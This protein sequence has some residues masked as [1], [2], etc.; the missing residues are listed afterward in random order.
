MTNVAGMDHKEWGIWQG[1]DL[2]DCLLQ[3]G[4]YIFVRFFVEAHVAV[5]N[6]DKA[7]GSLRYAGGAMSHLAISD[8]AADC[9]EQ[10]APCP[11]HTFKKTAAI[12]AIITKIPY[13]AFCHLLT[14]RSKSQSDFKKRFVASGAKAK[15]LARYHLRTK[16]HTQSDESSARRSQ[17]LG[18]R[19]TQLSLGCRE[20][21]VYVP[22]LWSHARRPGKRRAVERYD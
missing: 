11:S 13:N 8:S 4:G 12:N 19:R 18:L 22:E 14:F 2:R 10:S 9:P 7:Q 6:L 17:F 20:V 1:V 15:Q 16:R 5:A 21:R 3:R